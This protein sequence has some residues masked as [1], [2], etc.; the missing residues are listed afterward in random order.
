MQ[1]ADRIVYNAYNWRY[2]RYIHLC[3]YDYIMS[4]FPGEGHSMKADDMVE[5]YAGRPTKRL[6]EMYLVNKVLH[7]MQEAPKRSR[8]KPG[9]F[10]ILAN[11][12]LQKYLV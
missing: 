2:V 7:R 12:D 11:F 6:R 9:S 5:Y 10:S 1:E 3:Y 8:G 4:H